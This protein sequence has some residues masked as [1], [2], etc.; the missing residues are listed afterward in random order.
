[1]VPPLFIISI[2]CHLS[3]HG[4]FS[5]HHWNYNLPGLELERWAAPGWFMLGPQFASRG[6]HHCDCEHCWLSLMIISLIIMIQVTLVSSYPDIPLEPV[7]QWRRDDHDHGSHENY[8][9][10]QMSSI[11]IHNSP[12]HDS[13]SSNHRCHPQTKSERWMPVGEAGYVYHFPLQWGEV[14]SSIFFTI[15]VIIL[16]NLSKFSNSFSPV[17]NNF[18]DFQCLPKWFFSPQVAAPPPAPKKEIRSVWT[19]LFV[20]SDNCSS[21]LGDEDC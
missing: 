9:I 14:G 4:K 2:C 20:E 15:V 12:Q 8:E 16:E 5:C 17:L 21:S 18:S 10:I 3:L 13:W 7:G 11:F 6:F 1:M 19:F